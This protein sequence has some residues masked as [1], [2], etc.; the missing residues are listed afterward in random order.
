MDPALAKAPDIIRKN[1]PRARKNSQD[2]WREYVDNTKRQ[3]DLGAAFQQLKGLTTPEEYA[4]AIIRNR[5]AQRR[6]HDAFPKIH[7]SVM[8]AINE[9]DDPGE[10]EALIQQW[11]NN[12]RAPGD[13][14][15]GQSQ[16][17]EGSS[18]PNDNGADPFNETERIRNVYGD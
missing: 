10:R 8:D 12:W 2:A 18:D 9:A 3:L 7:K 14:Q 6:L 16:G 13:P 15:S 17:N 11:F 1:F 4:G 5:E